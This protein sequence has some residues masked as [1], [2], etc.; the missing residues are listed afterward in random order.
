M[1]NEKRPCDEFGESINAYDL[2][3]VARLRKVYLNFQRN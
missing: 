1:T 2:N 3:A